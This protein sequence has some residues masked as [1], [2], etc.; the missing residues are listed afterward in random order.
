MLTR[1]I[2]LLSVT[3][4]CFG[5]L[6][7][8]PE[9][10]S[11]GSAKVNVCHL[12]PGN[13]DN[14]H[15]IRISE[16]AMSKHLAHGDLA[17][18]CDANCATLCDDGDACTIDDDGQ[19]ETAGCPAPTPTDCDDE[20]F[21]TVDSCDSIEG[22]EYSPVDCGEGATCDEDNDRCVPNNCV[23]DSYGGHDYL[24]CQGQRDVPSSE[25]FCAD[26]GMQLAFIDDLAENAWVV[27]TAYNAYGYTNFEETSYWIANTKTNSPIFP[28]AAGEPNSGVDQCIHLMRYD[29]PQ[30]SLWNDAGCEAWT[31][32]WVCESN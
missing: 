16:N 12:P 25:S 9:I 24:I 26:E 17:E 21:C 2:L 19:C 1:L 6:V 29:I 10:A 7:A 22:C 15:T 30:L 5:A 18:D 27:D 11:A 28:W 8:M 3:I 31:W 14:Y 23:A 20:L 4:F 13:L 32:G